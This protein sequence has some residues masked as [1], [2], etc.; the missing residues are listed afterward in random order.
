MMA[1]YGRIILMH[2]TIIF[3]AWLILALGAPILAL[4][5]LIVLKIFS[6]ARAHHKEHAAL[7]EEES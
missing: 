2:V 7:Q 3:G 4:V 1:P 5:L 6:D